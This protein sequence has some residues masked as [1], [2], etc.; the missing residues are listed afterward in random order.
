MDLLLPTVMC[1]VYE[2]AELGVVG[3]F[4]CV[5]VWIYGLHI[6]SVF[7]HDYDIVLCR[8][9]VR[10]VEV[11]VLLLPPQDVLNLT[12]QSLLFHNLT[13]AVF[14]FFGFDLSFTL[15]FLPD[16]FVNQ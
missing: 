4:L 15:T 1:V 10:G 6:V 11:L 5:G 7:V 12:L 8:D 3:D 9:G 16:T 2:S 14:S 13:L